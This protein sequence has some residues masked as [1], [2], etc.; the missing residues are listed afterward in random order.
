MGDGAEGSCCLQHTRYAACHEMP[1][2]V[3]APAAFNRRCCAPSSAGTRQQAAVNGAVRSWAPQ[4]AVPQRDAD[5]AHLWHKFASAPEGPAKAAALRQLSTETSSRS[6]VDA[7]VRAS[8]Q[9]LLDHTNA[10]ALLRTKFGAQLPLLA[11]QPAPDNG[12]V[13]EL[14]VGQ[15]L[16]RPEGTPL[17]DDWDC[18]RVRCGGAG[19]LATHACVEEAGPLRRRC[20]L[21]A[22]WWCLLVAP[23]VRSMHWFFGS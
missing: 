14:V 23:Q 12:A 2:Y 10:L 11:A 13:A 6:R 3:C 22:S 19:V 20:S 8:V 7:E 4:G 15:E 5:L 21:A 16:P 9:R 17:V 18:L 1:R